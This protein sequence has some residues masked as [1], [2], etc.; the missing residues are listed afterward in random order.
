MILWFLSLYVGLRLRCSRP[1]GRATHN[2]GKKG[3][4]ETE[5]HDQ[6]PH[7]RTREKHI[8]GTRGREAAH[9]RFSTGIQ[10]EWRIYVAPATAYL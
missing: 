1:R 8:D 7:Q 2:Q 9:Q 6:G 3:S 5:G 4:C 10:A